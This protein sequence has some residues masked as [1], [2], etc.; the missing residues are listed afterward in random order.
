MREKTVDIVL[1]VL[2][3]AA[4][5]TATY[6]L[7]KAVN[8]RAE[9]PATTD[10]E[11]IELLKQEIEELREE[12]KYYRKLNKKLEEFL[13]KVAVGTFEVTAYTV[14]CGTG[15]GITYTGTKTAE[16]RTI[17]VDEEVIPLGSRVWIEGIGIRTA[18]DIGSL[19]KGN[20]ID[21]FVGESRRKALR[22]GRQ[23]LKVIYKE[24]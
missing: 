23:E 4:M 6:T 21:M 3:L 2:V 14:S 15:D 18:E 22:Y 5:F 20:V 17:A 16:G 7:T 9:E 19:V 24:G 11:V 12:N 10:K 13:D 8:S 1:I